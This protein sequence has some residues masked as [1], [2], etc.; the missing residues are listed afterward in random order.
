MAELLAMVAQSRCASA[1]SCRLMIEVMAQQEWREK[2]PA[3][4]PEGLLVANKTGGVSGTSNDAAI[5]YTPTGAPMVMVVFWKGLDH[6]AKGRADAAIAEIAARAVRAPR[7]AGVK[8][9]GAR[10]LVVGGVR[11]LGRAHRARP[12]RPRRRRGRLHARAHA[13][14]RRR[15][16]PR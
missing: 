6:Q 4:L 2:I 16:W 1:P 5:V 14:G 10:V 8:V 9:A 3:G 15:R 11:R 7:G 13:R 12:G